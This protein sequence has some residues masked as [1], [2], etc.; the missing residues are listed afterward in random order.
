MKED[1]AMFQIDDTIVSS[2]L[3]SEYFFCDIQACK[4]ACC[5]EGEWG[6]P[7]EDNEVSVLEHIYSK[8]KPFMNPEGISSVEKNGLYL[9]DPD[10]DK[11]TPLIHG[12]ECAFA[13]IENGI[14]RCAIEKA[15]ENNNTGFKK[16]VSCHLYPVRISKYKDFEAVNYHHWEICK[17]AGCLGKKMNTRVFEFVKEP[18]IRKYSTKWYEELS[19]IAENY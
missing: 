1:T 6:A 19:L 12:K 13:F 8:V 18:L 3:L 17:P 9:I 15:F 5:V 4:G 14:Y 10:G 11:V 2:E 16:P 7:L